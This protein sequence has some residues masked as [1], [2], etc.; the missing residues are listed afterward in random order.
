MDENNCPFCRPSQDD[1]IIAETDHAFAMCDARPL[2]TGHLLISPKN[3]FASMFDTPVL[4]LNHVAVLKYELGRRLLHQFH[5]VGVYEHGRSHLHTPSGDFS[6]AHVHILPVSDDVLQFSNSRRLWECKPPG[7]EL[8][9]VDYFYQEGSSGHGQKWAV[10]TTPVRNHCVRGLLEKALKA[11]DIPSLPLSAPLQEHEIAVKQT[12]QALLPKSLP[13][14]GRVFFTGISK[15]VLHEVAD[16][17]SRILGW[18]II[19]DDRFRPPVLLTDHWKNCEPVIFVSGELPLR[20]SLTDLQVIL[21]HAGSF[22]GINPWDALRLLSDRVPPQSL[23][24]IVLT[25]FKLRNNNS[26]WQEPASSL[27]LLTQPTV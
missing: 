19:D 18:P 14:Y 9:G 1:V 2:C 25:A 24:E 10:G 23:A 5:E 7:R 21:D 11:R 15:T 22:S 12:A 8:F 4:A 26:L 16:H 13:N 6:H 20:G 27:V 3:H 17:V